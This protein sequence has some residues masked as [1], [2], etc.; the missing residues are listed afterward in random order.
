MSAWPAGEIRLLRLDQI[1]EAYRRYRLAA[2]EAEAAMARS[3]RRYGQMSPIVVCLRQE[4]PEVI[5]CFKRLAAARTISGWHQLNARRVEV[6]E[7][8][9]DAEGNNTWLNR[10]S[11]GRK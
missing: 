1:G 3:L 5:D 2:P 6:D 9:P 10:K 7:R 11:N 4:R 8:G